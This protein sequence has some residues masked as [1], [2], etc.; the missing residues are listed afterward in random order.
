MRACQQMPMH[1][2]VVQEPLKIYQSQILH[3]LLL[4]ILMQHHNRFLCLHC[5]TRSA[6]HDLVH[7]TTLCLMLVKASHKAQIRALSH[8]CLLHVGSY[9]S[10]LIDT[11]AVRN[12][13]ASQLSETREHIISIPLHSNQIL[14]RRTECPTGLIC[15]H[16]HS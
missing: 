15:R 9:T 6:A 7:T 14:A 12:V 8:A 5:Q 16:M 11:L 3:S 10:A 2:S 4:L 13:A 1:R